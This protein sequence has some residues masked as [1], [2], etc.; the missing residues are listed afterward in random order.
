VAPTHRCV[1]C[2]TATLRRVAVDRSRPDAVC[3]ETCELALR[4][5]RAESARLFA[6]RSRNRPAV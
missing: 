3:S 5:I 1:I 6:E 4:T 2:K